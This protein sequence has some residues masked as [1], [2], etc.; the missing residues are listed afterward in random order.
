[1]KNVAVIGAGESGVGAAILAHKKGYE[2]FVSE[3]GQIS[4]FY[5][6]ELTHNNILF[7]EGGHD[8]EKLAK[9]DIIVK[10]P[11]IPDSSPVIQW[12]LNRKVYVISEIEWGS[13]FYSGTI[14]AVTGSNGKTTTSGLLYH[15]L[16]VAGKDVAL[17][18][19]YGKSFARIVAESDHEFMVLEVSSFQLDNISHFKPSVAILLNIT[20]DHLD[21]YDYNLDKY[22][23]AKMRIC[24]NQNE[25]DT[26]IFNADDPILARAIEKHPMQ[27]KM[28]PIREND[29]INGIP[30]KDGK[31][32]FDISIQGRHNLFNARCSVEACRILGISESALAEGLKSFVNLPHR[33]EVCRILDQVTFINDSKATNTDAVYFAL[34][35]MTAP[36]IWI[37]G[38][39]DKGNDYGVLMSL[40][41]DK[42]KAL[43]CLGVDNSKLR[44]AFSNVV[45]V[46]E[47]TKMSEAVQKAMELASEGDIVLLSPACASFDLFRNYMDRGDQF[48]NE[49]LK[50]KNSKN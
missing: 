12:A 40:V 10:S 45:P 17:G 15:L 24:E 6:N 44:D 27:S 29:Y 19:N 46:S 39:T 14:V 4:E 37:A 43:V 25:S 38:G 18:G 8:F 31:I 50:L 11:G 5:K 47:T 41:R 3:Y 16:K 35:A 7:E 32:I 26:F 23:D 2:V 49:V 9:F 42:V 36:V 13:R 22:A 34:E 33:L 21:R 30:S 28:I 48:K 20:P 1:M